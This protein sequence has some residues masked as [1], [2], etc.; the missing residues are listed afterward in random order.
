MAAV[1]DLC[2]R[3]RDTHDR[4]SDRC[5]QMSDREKKSKWSVRVMLVLLHV[6]FVGL[7][8]ALKPDLLWRNNGMPWYT[9]MYL[10]LL[11]ATI[12]QYFFT[13]YSEPGYVIDAMRAGNEMHATFV[14]T[15][16]ISKQSSS[17]GANL[18]QPESPNSSSSQWFKIVSDLHPPSS[19]SREWTCGY[20]NVYQ[21][22]RSKHCHECDKCVLQFD[23]HCV[24]LGTCIGL[25]NH[26]RFWWYL[27]FQTSLAAWTIILYIHILRQHI[28]M[29][30]WKNFLMTLALCILIL[31]FIFLLLLC[32]FH[33]YLAMTNQTTYELARRRRVP[34]LRGLP[35]KV[36]PFSQG[37]CKNLSTFCFSRKK[38]YLLE[39]IPSV[40]ELQ[41]RA[42]SHTWLDCIMCKCFLGFS[43]CCT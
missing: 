15:C 11:L 29:A 21:P 42:V 35:E 7:I 28:P 12:S 1:D 43:N 19:S 31:I 9:M 27:L 17:R 8:F 24:W 33:S 16:T 18:G 6:I 39:P 38:S 41:N 5:S 36:Q 40:E 32:L 34:Y 13:S 30:W 14:N 4:I 23:H 20:C 25:K 26:C 10:A 22:P 3:I 37:I 2:V